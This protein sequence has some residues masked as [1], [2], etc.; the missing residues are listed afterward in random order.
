MRN[1]VIS[2]FVIIYLLSCSN[3]SAKKPDN[4][5]SLKTME[6]VIYDVYMLNAIKISNKKLL[7]NEE[8]SFEKEIF[9]KYN[10][11]SLQFAK[12]NDFYAADFE[13]YKAL[14][15]RI[16]KRMDSNKKALEQL[17]EEEKK[18]EKD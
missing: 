16:K 10:I 3:K 9:E 5:I 4:L 13:T 1:I 18:S 11:D 2:F 15:E 6:E 7:Q 14:I 12:S 8:V 17:I